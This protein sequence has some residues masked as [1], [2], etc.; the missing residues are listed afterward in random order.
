MKTLIVFAFIML[1]ACGREPCESD[2][3]RTSGL[4]ICHN[5]LDVKKGELNLA[6]RLLEQ[7]LNYIYPDIRFL[8]DV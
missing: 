8:F 1:S 6:V 4:I 2:T 3:F 7:E 5:N